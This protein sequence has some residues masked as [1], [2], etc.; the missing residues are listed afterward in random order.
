MNVTD[1]GVAQPGSAPALG[2]GGRRSESGRPDHPSSDAHSPARGAVT[3]P[4]EPRSPIPLADTPRG[5]ALAKR[6]LDLTLASL[7]LVFSGPVMLGVAAAVKLDS[8]GPVLFRQER[9]GAGGRPFTIYKFRTMRSDADSAVH[10]AHVTRL[11]RRDETSP[12]G[13]APD[14]GRIWKP[15]GRDPRLTR[16]GRLLRRSHLDELPQLFNIVRG[17][18]SV[19]GPRPPIPYE[20]E[21]Y[22]DWQ[23]RRLAV[24]PGLTGLWQVSGWGRLTFEEGVLLDLEYVD[25]RSFWLDLSIMFRTLR[26]VL[27]RGM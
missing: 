14:P 6:A 25:R 9:L 22:E 5:Y 27:S 1:R 8:P 2:A 12:G 13:G 21:L 26:R 10:R 19:V 18:M 16:M 3:H 24:R 7:G 20:V 11:L 23:R 4:R 15:I 17:E